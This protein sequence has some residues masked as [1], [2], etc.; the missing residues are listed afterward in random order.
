MGSLYI[1]LPLGPSRVEWRLILPHFRWVGWKFSYL[2]V[3]LTASQGKRAANLYHLISSVKWAPLWIQF[4][5]ERGKMEGY[6][7]HSIT[8]GLGAESQLPGGP[9]WHGGSREPTSLP[10]ITSFCLLDGGG[11]ERL[12]S[13]WLCWHQE[14][15]KQCLLPWL[16]LLHSTS[17]MTDGDRR[18][19]PHSAPL[20]PGWHCET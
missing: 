13:L 19:T 2:S 14:R 9:H 6:L 5:L 18:S 15:G 16:M 8:A 4:P 11:D 1:Q 17:L 20:T 10:P 3:M 12:I 7:H